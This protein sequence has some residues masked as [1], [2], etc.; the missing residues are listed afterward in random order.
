MFCN[1]SFFVGLVAEHAVGKRLISGVLFSGWRQVSSSIAARNSLYGLE[2][3]KNQLP[4][5]VWHHMAKSLAVPAL[6]IQVPEH[7]LR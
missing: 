3:Q 2:V 6:I 7:R 4:W 1:K 5:L